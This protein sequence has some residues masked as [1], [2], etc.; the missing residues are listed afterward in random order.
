MILVCL[1]PTIELPF[2]TNLKRINLLETPYHNRLQAYESAQQLMSENQNFR[3][4]IIGLE[5]LTAFWLPRTQYFSWNERNGFHWC[6][7]PTVMEDDL[8]LEIAKAR[9]EEAFLYEPLRV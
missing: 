2:E 5:A 8:W 9:L 4:V 1:N 3:Y 6:L 7:F